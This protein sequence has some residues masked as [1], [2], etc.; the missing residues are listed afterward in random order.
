MGA[1]QQ[2]AIKLEFNRGFDELA[3]HPELG[4]GRIDLGQ[5]V[6]TLAF[7]RRVI[8]YRLDDLG[9]TVL[10]ILHERQVLNEEVLSQS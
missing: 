8:V 3:R 6:R 9:L 5:N 2:R 10:R 1:E 7:G 4:R